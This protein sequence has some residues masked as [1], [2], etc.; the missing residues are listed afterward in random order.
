MQLRKTVISILAGM[1]FIFSIQ[2]NAHSICSGSMINPI[3]DVCWQCIF[4]IRIAGVEIFSAKGIEDSSD[5]VTSPV[6]MCNYSIGITT[7]FWEP[8]RLIETVKDSYCF[9]AI[10]ASMGALENHSGGIV[11]SDDD[12]ANSFQQVHYYIFPVWMM[13]QLFMDLNCSPDTQFDLAYI[14]E[15]DPLWNNDLLA[16]F[17][18][19]EALLFGNQIAQMSC[20]AD[21]VAV[22]AGLPIN[23]LFWCMGSWGSAYPL[24]GHVSDSDYVQ[25]NGA[26][27]A[28][29]IYK[30]S[31][32]MLIC[33]VGA[34]EC[35]CYHTPI[36]I[37]DHY[38]L[39]LAKPVRDSTCHP[40]G[41]SGLIWESNKNPPLTSGSDNFL[42][43]MHR[44]NAC[45][46][47]YT[48]Y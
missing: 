5:K 45:C 13:L 20:I 17:I 34:T 16:F 44:K 43:I 6:C 28:R 35:G 32:E 31:R 24:T 14:T 39:Q 15:I 37:K 48:F 29:M 18:N 30:L 22:N 8:A 26:M 21:S 42:W 46:V 27:A 41:R 40:I 47:V 11:S 9:P 4:P 19:P 10:G 33:D 1:I 36:W 2:G 3:T 7:S 12:H 38:R 23:E 25:A